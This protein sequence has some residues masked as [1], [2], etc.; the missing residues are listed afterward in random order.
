MRDF[1]SNARITRITWLPEPGQP[2]WRIKC[3]RCASGGILTDK[4]PVKI[5]GSD[6]VKEVNMGKQTKP[7]I[8]EVLGVEVGEWFT[9]PG[10]NTS[11]QVT[12]N[13]FLKCADGDLMMCVP[14]LINHPD[15]IIRKPRWTG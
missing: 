8:C 2:K 13:G 12:E 3:V 11:F 5:S 14:T 1:A 9:H 7:R 10:M 4:D 15:R 6:M